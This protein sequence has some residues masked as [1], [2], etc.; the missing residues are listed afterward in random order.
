[1]AATPLAPTDNTSDSCASCAEPGATEFTLTATTGDPHA[2]IVTN[3][4]L[5]RAFHTVEWRFT[6][7]V[8]PGDT[9]SYE[10]VTVLDVEGRPG[11]Y[12]HRDVSTLVPVAPPSRN[13]LAEAGRPDRAI[14]PAPGA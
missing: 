5:D 13:P 10:E 6:F 8:G 7:R 4:F 11:P 9:W 2:G 3:D 12:E 1:V 14:T